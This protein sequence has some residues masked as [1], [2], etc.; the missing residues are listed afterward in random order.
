MVADVIR[1]AWPWVILA[2]AIAHVCGWLTTLLWCRANHSRGASSGSA[3]D[4]VAAKGAI[5]KRVRPND[6]SV[7]EGIGPKIA[8]LLHAAGVFTWEDLAKTTPKRIEEILD[9][10]GPHYNMHVPA[11][12]PRQARL[13]ADGKWAEFKELTDELTGG[14]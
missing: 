5:G 4:L 14:R 11:T 3:L 9:E 10:A 1:D 6:L 2:F 12:W 8:R 7:I 13:L